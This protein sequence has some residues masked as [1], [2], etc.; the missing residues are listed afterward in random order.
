[1]PRYRKGRRRFSRKRKYVSKATKRYVKKAIA[2]NIETKESLDVDDIVTETLSA[3]TSQ[4]TPL[5][6][7]AQGTTGA[8]RIGDSI[9][10]TYTRFRLSVKF[11]TTL[12]QGNICR[13]M[14]GYTILSGA[15]LLTYM[16]TLSNLITQFVDY[17]RVIPVVDRTYHIKTTDLGTVKSWRFNLPGRNRRI[18]YSGAA[19][20]GK[21]W[22]P[23][24]FL[25]YNYSTTTP[26]FGQ[27]SHVGF[28]DA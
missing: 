26:S 22:Q 14:V 12:A 28:K 24:L 27:V 3:Q 2:K 19:M 20:E 25:Y 18:D 15:D 21:I 4:W 16:N 13:V 9:R 17:D 11:N 8:T 7:I 23:F 1:M 5:E 10:L 6:S